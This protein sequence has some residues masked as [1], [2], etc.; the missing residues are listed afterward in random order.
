MALNKNSKDM[1]AVSIDGS[2]SVQNTETQINQD[3]DQNVVQTVDQSFETN[4]VFNPSQKLNTSR[5]VVLHLL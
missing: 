1:N 4:K 3:I 2:T 5:L